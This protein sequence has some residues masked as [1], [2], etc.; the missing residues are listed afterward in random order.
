[1]T[2]KI[3]GATYTVVKDIDEFPINSKIVLIEDDD[4]DMPVFTL[5]SDYDPLKKI[6]EMDWVYLFM[7]DVSLD[8][9][10][11]VDLGKPFEVSVNGIT[12]TI[13]SSTTSITIN[14][15]TNAIEISWEE[16]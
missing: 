6:H 3:V 8:E 5:K 15:K 13:Q 1:M 4:S 11:Q 7:D 2:K 9:D 10:P 12:V 14:S 16:V